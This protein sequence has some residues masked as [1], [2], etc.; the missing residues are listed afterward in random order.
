MRRTQ[1]TAIAQSSERHPFRTNELLQCAPQSGSPTPSLSYQEPST[2]EVLH[3]ATQ[4]EITTPAQNH[5]GIPSW[6]S[7]VQGGMHKIDGSAPSQSYEGYSS[8]TSELL[9]CV[10]PSESIARTETYHRFSSKTS[11]LLHCAPQSN[12]TTPAVSYQGLV[13][14]TSETKTYTGLL[15]QTRVLPHFVRNLRAQLQPQATRASFFERSHLHIGSH[16]LIA[17][18]RS[19]VTKA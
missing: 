14:R 2:S 4:S 18:P 8:Q 10:P 6:E 5:Q 17:Q 11:T 15:A 19:T 1:S 12:S 3:N 13:S 7:E 9:S 16:N